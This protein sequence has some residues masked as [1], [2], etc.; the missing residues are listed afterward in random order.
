[1]VSG[2]PAKMAITAAKLGRFLLFFLSLTFLATSQ[3]S[4]VVEPDGS[5]SR[6]ANRRLYPSDLPAI[7]VFDDWKETHH[8]YRKGSIQQFTSSQKPS[9]IY[10]VPGL[11]NATTLHAIRRLLQTVG[12]LDTDPDTVDGFATHEFFLENS[13]IRAGRAGKPGFENDSL[14]ASRQGLRSELSKLTQDALERITTFVNDH[15]AADCGGACTPCYSLLRRYRPQDR[16]S[17][18]PHRD[19]HA[20]VTSVLP[21]TD[22]GT[23]YTG[24]LYV[25]SA[26][27]QRHFVA[28][29]AG[30]AVVHQSDLLHGVQVHP[31]NEQETLRWSWILWFRD[32]TTCEDRLDAEWFVE[33]ANQGDAVCQLL[34]AT[35]CSTSECVLEW[36]LKAARAGHP[37]ACIKIARAY[38]GRLPSD[39]AVNRTAARYWFA[40]AV[41]TANDPDAH[42]G[43]AE[44][45]LQETNPE[46]YALQLNKAVYHLEQSA[47]AHHPFAQFN[48]GLAHLFGYATVVDP[49]AAGD[50]FEQ[51]GLPEGYFARA[52]YYDSIGNTELRQQFQQ[53]AAVLG[54][55]QEWRKVARQHTGYGGAGGIDLNLPWPPN[56]AGQVPPQW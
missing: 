27:A 41:E 30:E 34:H 43:L 28:L 9:T 40:R 37:T 12:P 15:H 42:Y 14:V 48:L 21:L 22:Y 23:E 25:A 17:H 33:C 56:V 54:F 18:A 45:A 36:N 2:H 20:L 44:M 51:S 35:K 10:T 11:L 38:L 4:L 5:T 7:S 46:N 53:R 26:T 49:K 31:G 3:E 50:W 29:E 6:T 55:G 1:M 39:L 52:M 24:G 32:S 13:D 8:D 16:V 47:L 19:G